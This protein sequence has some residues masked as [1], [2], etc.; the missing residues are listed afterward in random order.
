M[1]NSKQICD[2]ISVPKR[3][4]KTICLTVLLLCV[5]ISTFAQQKLE[6]ISQSI[7]VDDNVV[8][9]LNTNYTNI[10]IETW[11][12]DVIE[13]EAYME[14]D[15][16]T[17]EELKKVFDNWQVNVDGSKESVRIKTGG[18]L[19]LWS[20]DF[21]LF[22]ENSFD[23]SLKELEIKLA[24]LPEMPVIEGIV[25]SLHLED[26]PKIPN[27]PDLPEGMNNF[28]FDYDQYKKEGEDYLERWSKEYEDK[29][30]KEYS[31]KMK[32][33]AEDFD[34]EEW[35]AYEKKMEAWGEK[36][37]EEF[38]EKFGEK[39]G[40]DMEEW[41]EAFGERMEAW[42]EKLEQQLEESGFEERM[43]AWGEELSKRIEEQLEGIEIEEGEEDNIFF[44]SNSRSNSKVKKTIKLKMPKKAK[45]KM[46]VRHGELKFA[47]LINNV[48]A[49]I[50]HSS[51]TAQHIDGSQTSI[52]VS[53]SP[54]KIS[55]WNA[56]ELKLNYV[57]QARIESVNSLVLSANSSNVNLQNVSSNA[58][59]DGSFGD[60]VIGNIS[61]S[62]KNI[63]LVLENSDANL[64]LPNSDYSLFYK[65]TRSIFNNENTSSK[66]INNDSND[67]NKTIVINAKYSNIVAQ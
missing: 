18:S 22:D 59:I 38:G 44:R 10:E 17:K 20:N 62:F 54:V 21:A 46:N 25:E 13:I 11:N 8:I 52:N 63:N 64:K 50:S 12:K 7:H 34:E 6:K 48:K 35:K 47:S 67:S 65:G 30:G 4:G 33:W 19:D 36:F 51:L 43:E 56:G 24:D 37:G 49:D 2:Y 26:M 16:L 9:D 28:N 45:L 42:G 60:L 3:I 29:Y 23:A 14:S 58:I 57:D 31:Q 40:K 39:F 61:N 5:S 53:Y 55:N 27:L 15:K 41:G 1:K 66:T 32:D